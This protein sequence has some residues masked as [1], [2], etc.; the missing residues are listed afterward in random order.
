MTA[1]A[2]LCHASEFVSIIIVLWCHQG[3]H[4]KKRGRLLFFSFFSGFRRG[5][6]TCNKGPRDSWAPVW[7]KDNICRSLCC[8]GDVVCWEKPRLQITHRHRPRAK[9]G[10]CG[11]R[12]AAAALISAGVHRRSFV[13]AAY[14]QSDPDL[15]S[16]S[17]G[18]KTTRGSHGI[19]L[20]SHLTWAQWRFYKKRKKAWQQMWKLVSGIA[21]I[22][23][24]CCWT[25]NQR[26][27]PTSVVPPVTSPAPKY[28]LF[29]CFVLFFY[30]IQTCFKKPHAWKRTHFTGTIKC[31]YW[32]C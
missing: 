19:A 29:L 13:P 9:V 21:R 3:A 18:C 22:P 6:K 20:L 4:Q 14:T 12:R 23:S 25:D 31:I 2:L 16:G 30:R 27:R 1:A 7:L 28:W 8:V 17:G 26:P 11:V 10:G 24:D 5:N 32:A 15:N